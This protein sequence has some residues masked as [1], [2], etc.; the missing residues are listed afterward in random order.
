MA[1]VAL[2]LAGC[3]G[4]SEAT[5]DKATAAAERI[6]SAVES[7]TET[8][9]ITEDNDP[10]DMIGRPNGYDA[11]VVI[12]DERAEC[13]DLGVDCGATVEEFASEGDAQQRS[14]YIQ[15]LLDAAPLLGA[16]YHYLNGGLL[17]RV[18]GELPPSAAD[19]YEAAFSG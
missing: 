5:S 19:E 16:E 12:Y 7:I 14:D 13:A 9:E 3:S 15:G 1:A 17:L 2:V 4:D 11:A 8:T 18:S 10:N 6:E